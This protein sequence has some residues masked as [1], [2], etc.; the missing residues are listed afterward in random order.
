MTWVQSLLKIAI[1]SR[2]P[3]WTFGPILFGIGIIHSHRIPKTL[4]ALLVAAFQIF[5]LSIPLSIIVFGINDVYDYETDNRNPRKLANGLQGGVLKPEDHSLVRTS[6][7]ISTSFI[8]GISLLTRQ[9]YNVLATLCLVLFGWQYSS[10][11][12]RLKEVPVLDSLSNGL[13]VFLA[14]FCGFSFSG[15]SSSGM[16]S[17]GLMLSL[18]TAAIHA[19]GAVVDVDADVAAGQRTIATA[20][21]QRP[22][23]IFGALCYFLAATTEEP[24]SIFGVYLWAG[25]LVML[26]PCFR[27]EL[28]QRAF[29]VIVYMSIVCSAIWLCVRVGSILKGMKRD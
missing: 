5:S 21:G 28:A 22:T 24:N 25:M 11:P 8:I 23:A 15:F 16:S 10:P 26:A 29:E 27:V 14:W 20:L 2:P 19:L 17:K 9:R 3:S 12:L 13:I 18:C 4:P 1:A 6:A 7:Y